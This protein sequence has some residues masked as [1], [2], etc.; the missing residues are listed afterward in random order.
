MSGSVRVVSNVPRMYRATQDAMGQATELA[1]RYAA[2]EATRLTSAKFYPPASSPGQPPAQR[3]QELSQSISGTVRVF[4]DK[5]GWVGMFGTSVDYGL[6]LELGTSEM[7]PRPFLRPAL[8]KTVKDMP[9]ILRKAFR[10][11]YRISGGMKK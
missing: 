9:D 8:D 2:R 3:Q 4:Q 5:K 1:V 10:K 7:A 11:S 6:Y